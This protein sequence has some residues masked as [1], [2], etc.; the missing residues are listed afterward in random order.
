M[1]EICIWAVVGIEWMGSVLRGL[2]DIVRVFA[3]CYFAFCLFCSSSLYF[4]LTKISSLFPPTL[5]SPFV[6]L[7]T[8]ILNETTIGDVYTTSYVYVSL[9]VWQYAM[10]MF[11]STGVL[12]CFISFPFQGNYVKYIILLEI[13]PYRGGKVLL[14]HVGCTQGRRGTMDAN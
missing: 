10:F 12:Q 4:L 13:T 8:K 7:L 11:H 2:V 5:P 3:S 14:L 6:F 9:T 1:W